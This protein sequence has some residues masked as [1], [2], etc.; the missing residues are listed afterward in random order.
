MKYQLLKAKSPVE[1]ARELNRLREQ[2][3]L[4]RFKVA[5]GQQKN[6]RQLRQLKRDIARL[7]TRLNEASPNRQSPS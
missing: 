6:V 5:H 1:L 2:L 7:L 3:R 4:D